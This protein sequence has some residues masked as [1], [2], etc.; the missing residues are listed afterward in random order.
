MLRCL[1][2]A[3]VEVPK[4]IVPVPLICIVHSW[5]AV[6]RPTTSMTS[7]R[8]ATEG[9]V[10]VTGFTVLSTEYPLSTAAE[11]E[12]VLALQVRAAPGAE[13]V[14]DPAALAIGIPAPAVNVAATGSAPVL[15]IASCP[16]VNARL[17]IALEAPPIRMSC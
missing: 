12:A 4:V 8:A 9:S 13:I 10:I 7:P 2:C 6:T 5:V 3:P 14:I 11:K 17:V 15:P 1:P 16:F